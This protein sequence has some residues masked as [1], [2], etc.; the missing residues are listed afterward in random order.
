[1]RIA[2]SILAADFSRLGQ[3]IHDAQMAGAELI[4]IDV[5][6]G[7]FVPNIAMGPL[8]VEAARRSTDLPLDVHLMM[9]EPENMIEAFAKAGASTLHVH[10]ETGFHIHRTLSCIKELGCRAGIAINPHTPAIVLTEILPLLD[11]V[12]VMT[13]NPGFGGQTLIPETLS[14]VS[15]LRK[16]ID[17]QELAIEVMVDGGVNESTIGQVVEA[18]ADTLVVGSAFFS[19]KFTPEQGMKRLQEALQ[20]VT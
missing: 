16:L 17:S 19:T 6:D 20:N 15:Q 14:K 5:M 8:I 11:V 2:P 4:H 7:R 9:V 10:W 1:M 3:Q 12:L 13:V 18:G